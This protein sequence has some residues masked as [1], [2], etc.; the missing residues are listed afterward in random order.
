[1]RLVGFIIRI[2]RDSSSPERQI[3][4]IPYFLHL[5]ISYSNVFWRTGRRPQGVH[6]MTVGFGVP[7]CRT[8][9]WWTPWGWCFLRWNALE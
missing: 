2:Y 8:V 7:E 6:H 1:V 5:A 3:R 4:T 9:T